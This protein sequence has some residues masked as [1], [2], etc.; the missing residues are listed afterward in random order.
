M[1]T[2]TKNLGTFWEYLDGDD[3]PATGSFTAQYDYNDN[4]FRLLVGR[5]INTTQQRGKVEFVRH[6]DGRV[7]EVFA[8]AGQSVPITFP[9]N[10]PNAVQLEL[11]P[12]GKLDGCDV[13]VAWPG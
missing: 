3:Q 2:I 1:A 13:N 5:A 10:G 4:T 9:S 7:F 6:S 8:E 12:S 11:L